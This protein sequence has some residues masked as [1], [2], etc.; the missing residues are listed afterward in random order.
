VLQ[1]LAVSAFLALGVAGL[2]A[3]YLARCDQG[4][5]TEPPGLVRLRKAYLSGI[6][7]RGLIARYERDGERSGTLWV[8]PAWADASNKEAICVYVQ[9]ELFR[10]VKD[11]CSNL[12]TII[13]PDGQ[14]LGHFRLRKHRHE[15]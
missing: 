2:F 10:E 6:T 12:L 1:R 7:E 4:R 3:A 8:G 9:Q 5:R 14:A 15:G 11:P 13:G